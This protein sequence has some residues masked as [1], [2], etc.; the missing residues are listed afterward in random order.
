MWLFISVVLIFLF[1]ATSKD[2]SVHGMID[3]IASDF[4]SVGPNPLEIKES[5]HGGNGGGHG[6]HGGL[7]GGHGGLGGGHGG[8]GGGHR[9]GHGGLRGGYGRRYINVGSGGGSGWDRG[10]LWPWYWFYET[11]QNYPE[12]TE[13]DYYPV[14]IGL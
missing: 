11:D 7:G 4:K 2:R 8:L 12:Y 1:W 14:T 13:T 5:F 3:S 6:G 9:G 10:W